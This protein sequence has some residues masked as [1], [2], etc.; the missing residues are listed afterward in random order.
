MTYKNDPAKDIKLDL[1]NPN[2]S[3][4]VTTGDGKKITNNAEI[5]KFFEE[6][7]AKKYKSINNQLEINLHRK[8]KIS[9]NHIVTKKIISTFAPR[10]N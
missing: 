4:T 10:I 6:S 1:A 3:M 5:I 7:M 2:N 9:Q 8:Q